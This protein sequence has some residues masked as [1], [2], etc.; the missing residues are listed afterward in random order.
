M[1]D[2]NAK[3]IEWNEEFSEVLRRYWYIFVNVGWREK[4]CELA[5]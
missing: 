5:R 2:Q 1:Q 4:G 3:Q